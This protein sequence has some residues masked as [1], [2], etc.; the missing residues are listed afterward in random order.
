MSGTGRIAE[1]L[2]EE[3][4]RIVFGDVDLTELWPMTS[5]DFAHV[6]VLVERGI[7]TAAVARPLLACISSLR[8]VDFEPLRGKEAPRGLYLMYENHLISELGAEVGGSLHTG[9][10]RND[11]KATTSL[12]RLRSVVRDLMSDALDLQDV[13]LGQASRYREVVM[14]V[15][16]HFQPA[17]PVTYG[18]YLL[19]VATALGRDL[20]GL[21]Q[22]ADGLRAC[23]MGACG[24]GG[25]DLPLDPARVAVLLG[26]DRP[27]GNSIDA[28]ASRDTAL[29]VL[30]AATSL[31]LTLS[32]FATD[33]Q[34]WTTQE[35]A[36]LHLP[37]SLVGS[38]SIMPQKRNAF[39]LE[40]VKA[41]PAHVAAAAQALVTAAKG[42]PFTNS[43]EVGTE[44][45]TGLWA[46]LTAVAEA[47]VLS[48]LVVAGATPLPGRMT[49]R[50]VDGWTTATALA[51]EK[52][53]AG[54]PFRT[55]HH[56]VGAVVLAGGDD[57][58]P[59]P[60]TAAAEAE[61]GGGP[62]P[63]SQATQREE[64]TLAANRLRQE[65]DA[66]GDLL[67]ERALELDQAVA[68]LMGNS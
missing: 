2:A 9:R 60:A 59:D 42:T 31:A 57:S 5:V 62:G 12:L 66:A 15:Y 1:P 17:V 20:A 43:I 22:A 18:H 11:L 32:R 21:A 55:A 27:A 51:N 16:T 36:L 34:L 24:V 44:G 54:V 64:L 40:H 35:F 46:G 38:S 25:T 14:P 61:H 7:L 29:R 53:R 19:G 4:R 10:S 47:V 28:V 49:E 3:A 50:A 67:R 48:R 56:D 6:V 33:V 58:R 68:N 26:F 52:V 23:P 30:F 13:L 8:E 41:K 65:H 37:D 45:V 39:L 63:V